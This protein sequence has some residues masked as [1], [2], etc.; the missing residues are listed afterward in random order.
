MPGHGVLQFTRP[1]AALIAS[2]ETQPLP[3]QI[4]VFEDLALNAPVGSLVK[5]Q[6]NALLQAQPEGTGVESIVGVPVRFAADAH[7]LLLRL[8]IEGQ[9]AV[10]G[11]IAL[12]PAASVQFGIKAKGR[13]HCS[14][15]RVFPDGVLTGAAELASLIGHW[16]LPAAISDVADLP[17]G[18]TLV[19]DL[20]GSIKASLG[21]TYGLKYNWVRA[22]RGGGVVG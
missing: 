1:D 4:I 12:A 22:A 8:G 9:A 16:K 10:S 6:G 5:V 19:A 11:Q 14:V 18:A 7:A 2:L 21:I 15:V 3:K 17:P 20:D 13:S